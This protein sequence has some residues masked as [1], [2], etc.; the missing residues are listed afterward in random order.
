VPTGAPHSGDD[1][2]DV[3]AAAETGSRWPGPDGGDPSRSHRR[4]LWGVSALTA[5][6][7]VATV[8]LALLV[9]PDPVRAGP[10]WIAPVVF[11]GYVLAVR[12]VFHIEYR[13]NAVTF[14]LSEV[15]TA[16]ALIF[17]SPA[18]AIGLRVLGGAGSMLL[19]AR[20]PSAKLWFNAS[21][22]AFEV[23]VSYTMLHGVLERAPAGDGTLVV[24]VIAACAA[25]ALMG[26]LF[27]PAAI[28]CFERDFWARLDEGIRTGALQATISATVAALA[29]TPALIQPG[30]IVV[31]LI[32]IIAVWLVV[33]R[34]GILVQRHRDLEAVN[35]L[36]R[37]VGRSLS[38]GEITRMAIETTVDALRGGRGTI[39]VFGPDGTIQLERHVNGGAHHGPAGA[40]DP[41]WSHVFA[42]THAAGVT[43]SEAGI[44]RVDRH[45]PAEQVVIPIVDQTGT[46]GLIVVADRIGAA[47]Q[48]GPDE[49][50][51]ASRLGEQLAA[52]L[53]N[54]MLHADIKYAAR[55]DNLTGIHNRPAFEELV[56]AELEHRPGPAAAAVMML[57][58]DRF[59]EI[60]DTFGHHVGDR[61]LVQFTRHVAEILEPDDIFARFGGDE[62]ALFV[63]RSDLAAI[64]ALADRIVLRSHEAL[65]LDGYDVVVGTSVGVAP[66]SDDDATATALIRQADIAMFTAKHN[67]HGYETYRKEIDRRTPERLAMLADLRDAI[68]NGD[69]DVHFQPRLDLVT[70]TIVGAEALA[71]WRHPVRGDVDPEDFIRIAEESGLIRQLTDSVLS[72]SLSTLSEWRRNGYDLDISVNLSAL[73]LVD[74]QLCRRIE[75]QLD[76]HDLPAAVV[77]LE[78]TESSL[79]VDTPRTMSTVEQLRELGVKLSLDDFGTA[80]SSLSYLR[81]LPVAELKVDRSFVSN[82]LIDAQDEVIVRSTIDLGHAL[83]LAVAAEGVEN[84]AMLEQL[85][86]AG[87]DL[88]QGYGISRPLGRDQ[89]ANWLAGTGHAIRRLVADGSQPTHRITPPVDLAE[90]AA[91]RRHWGG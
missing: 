42:H 16:L 60:N 34:Y 68:A 31:A 79:M 75:R 15:P 14:T 40:D 5:G 55:H 53:R 6:L 18:V 27:V 8:A 70:S 86:N 32:P 48:F 39:L 41:A 13:R 44:V 25:S 1:L 69:I 57:D 33:R 62:F 47:R 29:V 26:P 36:A 22:F 46:L 89:F 64:S 88:G 45:G 49:F 3:V 77:T 24:A 21:L 83:G 85:R 78:I 30:L 54:A 23:A 56:G 59:K 43:V 90:R 72:R 65:S 19:A 4:G 66:V 71:R 35:D 61:V 73:D 10:W 38:V 37:V 28:A 76:E 50:N 67:H 52:H 12:F 20:R 74:E 11:V 91:R 7:A 84:E 9:P 80:Y 87:C 58:L 2:A 81:R 51:R 63:R 17:L 82:L